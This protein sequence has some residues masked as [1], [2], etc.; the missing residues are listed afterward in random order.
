MREP[1]CPGFVFLQIPVFQRGGTVIS[2]KTSAGKST[3]WMIDISYELHVALD[4]EVRWDTAP[5][6]QRRLLLHLNFVG[7]CCLFDQHNG[8]SLPVLFEGTQTSSQL[9][10]LSMNI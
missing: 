1:F 10:P 2:L 8:S 6:L 7:P 9:S 4:A 5:F 3:E